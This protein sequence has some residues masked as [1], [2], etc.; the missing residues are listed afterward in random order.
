MIPLA[1]ERD[2]IKKVRNEYRAKLKANVFTRQKATKKY[3][4]DA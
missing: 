4:K 3:I 2:I 1:I